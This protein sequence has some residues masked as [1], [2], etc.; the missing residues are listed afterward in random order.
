MSY[1]LLKKLDP[2]L[3]ASLSAEDMRQESS[4]ELIASENFVS[5]AVLE[6]YT[7]TFTNKYAEGYPGRRYYGGCQ[8][9]DEV[10]L[11]AIERLKKIFSAEYVNVQPHSG[12]QANMAVFLSV[13]NPGD[14]ILGMD[15][16]HGGHLTHGSK[17]NFSGLYF[18]VVSYGVSED[19]HQIDFDDVLI[20]AKKYKPKLIIAGAS[21][22][23]RIIDFS[24][25]RQIANGVGALLMVDMAHVAG[26]VAAGEHPSPLP[27]ADFVTSTT[28][29]TLRG[30]R[31]G[32]ILTNNLSFEKKI[33]SRVFP[34]VQGG[35]LMHVIAS[36]ATAFREALDPSFI[37]YQKQVRKNAL[38]MSEVLLERGVSLVSGGTD[39]HLLL[40]DTFSTKGITGKNS[41][42]LLES[43][44]ITTNKNTIP[45]DSQSSMITSGIRIGTAAITT[46][47]VLDEDS[48][49]IAHLIA[50]TLENPNSTERHN[51]ISLK[52]KKICEKYPM[53]CFRL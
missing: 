3:F 2:E 7:S 6:A 22:Y 36:K 46:R 37:V 33:N 34:G 11:L 25:F 4:L 8:F 12:A 30:P 51:E 5:R 38:A 26:L 42:E 32:I 14:T 10:E 27:Y 13:L 9:A 23:P 19:T 52:V 16:S 48:K 29:K 1:P 18:N 41:Q 44:S 15:L 40:L 49:S 28:H 39:N 31:G 35:P 45:F 24:Q 20:K 21:S 17:V 50:D 53:D 43:V 47:G